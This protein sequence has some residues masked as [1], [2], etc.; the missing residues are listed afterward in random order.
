MKIF[1]YN[2]TE[3][4]PY[5]LLKIGYVVVA[6][7]WC[8]SMLSCRKQEILPAQVRNENTRAVD[9]NVQLPGHTEAVSTYAI[10]ENEENA[11]H[12]V[13]VLAFKVTNK[14]LEN[15]SETFAYSVTGTSISTPDAAN[16]AGKSFKAGL[17][18]DNDNNYRFVVLANVSEQLNGITINEG[19]RKEA[20]MAKLAFSKMGQWNATSVTNYD[21]FPMW[22]E[23]EPAVI[24]ANTTALNSIAMVRSLA[25][26]DVVLKETAVSNFRLS[27]VSLVNS[28]A[29]GL[30]AP[31]SNNFN[32]NTVTSESMPSAAQRNVSPVTYQVLSPGKS[33][34]QEIYAFESP[35]SSLQPNQTTGTELI[36]GGRY[37]GSA[38]D[39]YYRIA[40]MDGSGNAIP[41]LRNYKYSVNITA[42]GGAGY[43]SISNAQNNIPINM[44]VEL[45]QLDDGGLNVISTDG[46][47]LLALST[48]QAEVGAASGQVIPI[49]ISSLGAPWYAYRDPKDAGWISVATEMDPASGKWSLLIYI[50]SSNLGV[51]RPRTGKITVRL[52]DANTTIGRI[53][54][55]ITITQRNTN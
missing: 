16:S 12:T 45:K 44:E 17:K 43:A 20:V 18:I 19:E 6:I 14:G 36:I 5:S 32:G 8:I 28:Y 25:R 33:L 52:G 7:V 39:T 40:F 10:T 42:V 4:C 11:I 47:Y 51:S 49:R 34:Q 2:L 15:E 38:V 54:K 41:L 1:S 31:L 50:N 26:I 48:D 9:F 30:I 35:K 3:K 55:T 23:T 22:G 27:S 46:Q 29:E 24:T 13:N 37:K 53:S 21:A